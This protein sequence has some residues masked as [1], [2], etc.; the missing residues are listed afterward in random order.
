MNKSCQSGKL[1]KTENIRQLYN[2]QRIQTYI[3]SL[4]RNV[5]H[6]LCPFKL[7]PLSVCHV[8]GGSGIAACLAAGFCA[9]IG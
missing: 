9:V 1:N 7:R 3:I 5:N 4:L 6:T 2:E 8:L